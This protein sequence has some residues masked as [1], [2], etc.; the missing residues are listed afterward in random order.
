MVATIGLLAGLAFVLI[1]PPLGGYDE[2]VHYARAYQVSQGQL[3]AT[4]HGHE[5]GGDLPVAMRTDLENVLISVNRLIG[6]RAHAPSSPASFL[7]HLGDRSARGRE[8]FVNFPTSAVYSPVPYAPASVL[9]AIGRALGASTMLLIY[10]GRLGSL[11]GTVGLLT[12]A[13][14]RMPTRA[15]SLMVVALLPV[16][17]VQAAMLS[18]D[19]VTLALTL[20]V[21]A[22]A[23]RLAATPTADVSRAQLVELAAATV[24]LGFAKPPYILVA[25]ALAIPWRRHAARVRG[26]I[27]GAVVGGFGAAAA[28]AAYASHVYVTPALPV[29]LTGTARFAAYTHVNPHEQEQYVLHHPRAFVRVVGTTLAKFPGQ[30]AHDAVA[31]IPLW[32]LPAIF[33]ILAV[34]PLVVSLLARDRAD[35]GGDRAPVVGVRS[36]VLLL[37]L[38]VATLLSLMF[39][40]YVGWNAVHALR[41][42]A[43]QGRY[44]MPLIPLL[45]VALPT[46]KLSA[47]FD[48]LTSTAMV[49]AGSG[50]VLAAVAVALWIHLY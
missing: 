25:L 43:F 7:S 27:A 49:G 32:G 14:R 36:R 13:A 38:A 48:R 45:I 23:L 42:E 18:A 30:L 28:W 16:T 6:H 3:I 19:G 26:A 8:A 46:P 15:T 22:L 10:L 9:M 21:L 29:G 47:R 2:A 31:Q 5:L 44:L 12:L 35:D 34:V 41:I 40:A 4:H 17:I 37:A 20:L 11:L 50:A 33:A 1:V 24:A 39:L